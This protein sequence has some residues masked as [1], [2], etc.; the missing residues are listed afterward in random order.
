MHE[1]ASAPC[2]ELA[3]A[4][5]PVPNARDPWNLPARAGFRFVCVYWLLYCLPL[6]GLWHLIVPWVAVHVF[7]LSGPVLQ[8]RPTGSGDTTLD[9]IQ[10]LCILVIAVVATLIWSLADR[11]RTD[12]RFMHSWLRT[13]L[14][15]TLGFTLFSYGFAKVFP[16]QF[17]YPSLSRMIEPFGDFSPMGVLWSF[18][19]SS[20]GYTMFAGAAEVIGG[21]LLL[22]RRTTT[23]GALLSAAT[24]L[25]VVVL[26]FCYDV[27]VK[28]YSTNLLLMAVF[29]MAPDVGQLFNF[30]VLHRPAG[31][32]ATF[33][34]L[35]E[36]RGLRIGSLVL[37]ILLISV[38]LI[39]NVTGGYRAYQSAVVRPTRPPLYG[40]YQVERFTWKGQEVPPLMTDPIR[41]NMMIV[42]FPQLLSVKMMDGS[43]RSFASQ[44]DAAASTVTLTGISKI[45]LNYSWPDA[46]HLV[47]AGTMENGPLEIRMRRRDLTEFL[48]V[49]RGFHWISEA[50]FNR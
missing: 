35:F 17:A 27:P 42:Q 5:G 48:L 7:H 44:Y 33:G 11:K 16:I 18:M 6:T 29:L 10:N 12:Y 46:N 32:A 26:N 36:R 38:V 15:Y 25:N 28:L 3:S 47:L 43:V 45:V 50:P 37:K 8:Y 2:V 30:L 41:W 19:G 24:L 34:P 22:F 20:P 13:G 23:L 9:Y 1:S 39:Q 21:A 31:Q 14:R 4:S 49:N 40:L